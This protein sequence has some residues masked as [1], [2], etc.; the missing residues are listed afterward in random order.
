M[1]VMIPCAMRVGSRTVS[2]ALEDLRLVDGDEHE[3]ARRRQTSAWVR[4]PAGRP[5]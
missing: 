2:A 1:P 4:K 3:E 5:W